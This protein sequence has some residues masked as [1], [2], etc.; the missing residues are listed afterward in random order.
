MD[1]ATDQSSKERRRVA[2]A[3]AS[4]WI[5]RLH[6][7]NRTPELEA[8]FRRWL[9]ANPE[10][11]QEFERVTAVWE[12]APHASTA[13]LPRV[14]QWKRPSARYRWALAVV[15][16]AA[17][18]VGAWLAAT[19]SRDPVLVTGIGEQRL[20][21]LEDGTRLT[22]NSDS[23]LKVDYTPGER[24]VHLIRGEAFFEV[25]HNPNRPFIVTA[26]DQQVTAVGTAF[27]VRYEPDHIDVT[28]VEGKVS[29]TSTTEQA[30]APLKD[31]VSTTPKIGTKAATRAYLMTAGE[32]LRIAKAGPSK[33]DEP[34]VEAVTA[35]RRGEVMLDDTPLSDAVAE[36]NRYNKSALVIDESRIADLKVS[37]IYHTGDSGGFAATVANLYGLRVT[38]ANNGIHLGTAPATSR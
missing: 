33:L 15:L 23:E 38:E 35:W 26:G 8:G 19:Y 5:V 31:S 36:M 12:A 4:V 22:I 29:V 14:S 34:R 11:A 25:A 21:P 1:A 2:R 27:E 18:G 20:V 6:G 30:P 37:G 28:L 17:C 3:E 7:A 24:R 10:N 16:L 32:R 13:G 9:A